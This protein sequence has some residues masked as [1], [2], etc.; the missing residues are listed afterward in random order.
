MGGGASK[1][2]VTAPM[3]EITVVVPATGSPTGS[4]PVPAQE[5]PPILL[6]ATERVAKLR[7]AEVKQQL[8]KRSLDQKG[9]ESQLRQ[10]LVDAFVDEATNRAEGRGWKQ[11]QLRVP[12]DLEIIGLKATIEKSAPDIPAELQV[13]KCIAVAMAVAS[14]ENLYR[15]RSCSMQPPPTVPV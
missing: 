13:R 2:Y 11:L 10:R 15:N 9:K 7:K 8:G 5:L 14:A 12:P 4:G 6:R 1:G 3:I